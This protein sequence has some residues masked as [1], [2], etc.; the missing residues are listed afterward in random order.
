M[1]AVTISLRLL[2]V[3]SV[4]GTGTG[5]PL[6]V[7][8]VVDALCVRSGPISGWAHWVTSASVKVRTENPPVFTVESAVKISA[9]VGCGD[10][11]INFAIL[12][13]DFYKRINIFVFGFLS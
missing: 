3:V 13:F 1:V 10:V 8:V 6:T 4:G 9:S 11:D 7:V 12:V 5:A 2:E